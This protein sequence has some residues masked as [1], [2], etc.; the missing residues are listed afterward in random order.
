MGNWAICLLLESD[1]G[2]LR[3]LFLL[4]RW[5]LW[6][7]SILQEYLRI[8]TPKNGI[9]QNG[10]YLQIKCLQKYMYRYSQFPKELIGN[11]VP[12]SDF[13]LV[14]SNF[15]VKL[16]VDTIWLNIL[17]VKRNEKS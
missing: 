4:H 13:S 3:V 7:K 11:T 14:Y 2:L 10:Y 12:P 9:C 16:G 8:L 1:I 5:N 6:N 17:K 15:D